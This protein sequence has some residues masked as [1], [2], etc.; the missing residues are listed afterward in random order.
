MVEDCHVQCLGRDVLPTPRWTTRMRF[1]VRRHPFALVIVGGLL[2]G[3]GTALIIVLTAGFGFAGNGPLF[4]AGTA[5]G[6]AALLTGFIPLFVTWERAATTSEI[7]AALGSATMHERPHLATR[8]EARFA[9]RVWSTPM[10]IFQLV[11]LFSEVR[12]EH[13]DRARQKRLVDECTKIEQERF[14]GLL[15]GFVGEPDGAGRR[16]L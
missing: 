7:A 5:T 16:A 13:G 1:F 11:L 14:V 4:V 3:G 12:S 15:Q 2:A 6:F 8:I 9:T 10:T